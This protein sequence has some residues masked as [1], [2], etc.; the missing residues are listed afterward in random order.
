MHWEKMK[1]NNIN[2]TCIKFLSNDNN[3]FWNEVWLYSAIS[4]PDSLILEICVST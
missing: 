1:T 3:L 4:L 2:P